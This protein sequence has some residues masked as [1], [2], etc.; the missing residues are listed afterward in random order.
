VAVETIPPLTAAGLRFLTAFPI[1]IGFSLLNGES[2][3]IPKPY[4]KFIIFFTIAYFMVPYYLLNYGERYVSSGITALLFSTMPVFIVI[5]SIFFLGERVNF[6][7]IFGLAIGFLGLALLLDHE[8]V[9]TTSST[10]LAGVA[11]ILIA[12]IL[13][14]YTY[15][16]TKLHA[17]KMSVITL[18]TLP[19][20][21]A[22]LLMTL[23]GLTLEPV[24][25]S[26]ISQRSWLAILYLGLVASV[27]GF[28]AYFELLKRM[29][30]TALSF[31]FIIFPALAVLL[32]SIFE[33]A[34]I[35]LESMIF[36]G[37]ILL[38]FAITKLSISKK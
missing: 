8:G 5:F 16:L 17:G 4:R 30:P 13:H 10:K 15:V 32:G 33:R 6:K 23:M 37:V 2:I 35:S 28:I 29:K 31:I 26:S 9:L 34:S 21:I 22:G 19:I 3:L 36:G 7:Q 12:A 25:F 14:A 24:T 27:G 11:A 18:N 20:G 1:F 38:G